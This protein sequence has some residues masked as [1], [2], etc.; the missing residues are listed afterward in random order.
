[1]RARGRGMPLIHRLATLSPGAQREARIFRALAD[2][3]RRGRRRVRAWRPPQ[4]EP[5]TEELARRGGGEKSLG[6]SR[7]RPSAVPAQKRKWQSQP[8]FRR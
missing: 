3:S 5:Q 1:M 6:P 7:R 4:P 2:F 8:R